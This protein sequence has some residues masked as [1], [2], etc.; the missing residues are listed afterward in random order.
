MGTILWDRRLTHAS[1]HLQLECQ[2]Q[3]ALVRGAR[4]GSSPVLGARTLRVPGWVPGADTSSAIL[5]GIG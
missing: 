5:S 2:V 1:E 4:P 3:S